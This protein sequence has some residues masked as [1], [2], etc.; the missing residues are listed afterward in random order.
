MMSARGRGLLLRGGRTKHRDHFVELP[1]DLVGL[2]GGIFRTQWLA[3]V[4][5]LLL[6][7]ASAFSRSK[8]LMALTCSE[9]PL[10][11]A[12]AKS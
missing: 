12:A 10:P 11:S 3:H 2:K 4:R 6:P 8:K 7:A 1:I 5:E 9:G